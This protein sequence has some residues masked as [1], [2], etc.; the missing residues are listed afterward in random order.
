MGK[1]TISMVIFNSYVTN[2]QRV[3][4]SYPIHIPFISHSY[5]I[6]IPYKVP[7]NHDKIPLNHC[8]IGSVSCWKKFRLN[9]TKHLF[10]L[11]RVQQ[12]PTLVD[13]CTAGTWKDREFMGFK[14]IDSWNMNGIARIYSFITL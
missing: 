9:F 8:D 14:G 2:Y 4:H 7:L 6:H 1:F 13:R 12:G 10:R 3:S 5:P 11:R